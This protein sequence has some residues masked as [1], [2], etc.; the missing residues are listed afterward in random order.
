[1]KA[2][3]LLKD[4]KKCRMFFAMIVVVVVVI[5]WIAFSLIVQLMRYVGIDV[6]L[7]VA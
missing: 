1:M 4:D 6:S 5:V 3:R 7:T 2:F